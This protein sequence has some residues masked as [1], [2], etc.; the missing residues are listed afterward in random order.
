MRPGSE[1]GSRS[2]TGTRTPTGRRTCCRRSTASRRPTE[3]W[4]EDYYER[5]VDPAAVE[6]VYGHRPLTTEIIF[7]LNPEVT[8][9]DLRA[10]IA[11]IGYPVDGGI[12]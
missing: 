3:H 11:E 1:A 5:E 8:L 6:H 9:A 10:D 12:H 4:A 2:R 7:L